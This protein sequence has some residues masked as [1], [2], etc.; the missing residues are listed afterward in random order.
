MNTEGR[1]WID[2]L[3][4]KLGY[5]RYSEYYDLAKAYSNLQ[6]ERSEQLKS[7]SLNA[8]T[9]YKVFTLPPD[10]YSAVY[11]L[12]GEVYLLPVK[13]DSFYCITSTKE[14]STKQCLK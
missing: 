6:R 8:T 7:A 3:M 9:T 4:A 12:N 13:P 14:A 2:K 1:S 11:Q 10:E 5:V